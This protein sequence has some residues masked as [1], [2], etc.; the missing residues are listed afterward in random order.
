MRGRRPRPCRVHLGHPGLAG[1]EQV[2]GLAHRRQ[3]VGVARAQLGPHLPQR[4]DLG[5][6]ISHEAH[7]SV[8]SMADLHDLIAAMDRLEKL[9]A[10]GPA[11]LAARLDEMW[12]AV[13]KNQEALIER[14]EDVRTSIPREIPV[15]EVDVLPVVRAV[16][17]KL[18]LLVD[19]LGRLGAKVDEDPTPA[20]DAV[21]GR[22]ANLEQAVSEA[23]RA[24]PRSEGALAGIPNALAEPL[25]SIDHRLS[26][27]ERMGRE[28]FE[29][30]QR[31][32]L[33]D[34]SLRSLIEP[35]EDL[36]PRLQH[37]GQLT[38]WLGKMEERL[39]SI[40]VQLAPLVQD[41]DRAAQLTPRF[42]EL[43]EAL[44]E[45][46]ERVEQLPAPGS[47][48][49]DIGARLD[50]IEADLQVVHEPF[51]AA[52]AGMGAQL[53]ALMQPIPR[54][55]RPRRDTVGE[56]GGPGLRLGRLRAR[57]GDHSSGRPRRRG[58]R[59]S[60][61]RHRRP[62][63]A[64][65]RHLAVRRRPPP[66]R[67]LPSSIW[68]PSMRRAGHRRAG[69]P[70]WPAIGRRARPLPRARRPRTHRAPPR[71][72]RRAGRGGGRAR[73]PT[74]IWIPSCG[75]WTSWPGAVASLAAAPSAAPA[76]ASEAVLDEVLRRLGELGRPDPALRE[77]R[78][79][80]EQLRLTAADLQAESGQARVVRA[81]VEQ[82][83]TEI[84]AVKAIARKAGT[85]DELSR[86]ATGVTAVGHD[87]EAAQ[88]RILELDR[89]LGSVHD[90]VA[91]GP[92]RPPTYQTVEAV[93]MMAQAI[94]GLERRLDADLEQLG[95][96]ID[97][98]ASA[99]GSGAAGGGPPS[100]EL[101]PG[102]DDDARLRAAETVVERISRLRDLAA[103]VGDAA[104]SE[105]RRRHS[106]LGE[107]KP[108][109]APTRGA[110]DQAVGDQ[111][112]AVHR[113]DHG[114]ADVARRRR[115]RGRRG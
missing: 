109:T 96:R 81:A 25:E 102:T 62:A 97:S 56:R 46:S 13:A 106:E 34:D 53:K 59:A 78:A 40:A 87:L 51:G 110:S 61:A 31:L 39:Q 114:D 1:V 89:K 88:Q 17:A 11:A 73:R 80:L 54:T 60:G 70:S 100:G 92:P 71:R 48:H 5:S 67:R 49:L 93:Q 77:L 24:T 22:L 74:S 30:D 58:G 95:R 37:V 69:R 50:R 84:E 90:E 3:G 83:T 86:V 113:L 20:I 55:T 111:L 38:E 76:P 16:E 47:D 45:L 63:R 85:A 29:L 57:R 14:I 104:R 107:G 108:L 19:D 115:R 32:G 64:R 112:E 52:L 21:A 15:P 6:E 42:D 41:P 27:V 10:G 66:R 7:G 23:I 9:L 8:W 33:I 2:D 12:L 98:L 91:R 79:S 18:A 101:T 4:L 75:D 82:L 43:Q 44:A 26:A 28:S 103:G 99:L 65:R 72:H 36:A 94:A 68:N 35:F 105:M